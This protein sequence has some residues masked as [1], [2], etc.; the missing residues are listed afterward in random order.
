METLPI[1]WI[2]ASRYS[3]LTGEP[4]DAIYERITDGL[5]AAGKHYKRTGKRTLWIN[6]PAVTEWIN[7]QP[8]VEAVA[9]PHGAK[10]KRA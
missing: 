5:W 9:F 4:M 6:L 1:E 8:H 10:P 2:R 3:D 7:S